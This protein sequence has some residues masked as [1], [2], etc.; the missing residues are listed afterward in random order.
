MPGVDPKVMTHHLG[1]CSGL[2]PI[3]QKKWSFTLERAKAID[4]EVEKL[5]NA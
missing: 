4:T 5:I 2:H 3:R 1:R